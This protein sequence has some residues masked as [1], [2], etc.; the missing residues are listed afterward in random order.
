MTQAQIITI[1]IL[2]TRIAQLD[3]RFAQLD[4]RI[5]RLEAKLDTQ[6]AQ[7]EVKIES[8]KSE[9]IRWVVGVMLGNIAL[10]VAIAGALLSAFQ[11]SR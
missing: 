8:V 9:L 7:L 3:T 11:H 5:T 2:D 4:T 10:N 6:V 1:P